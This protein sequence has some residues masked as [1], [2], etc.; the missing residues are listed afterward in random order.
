MVLVPAGEFI[1]G[2]DRVEA[3]KQAGEFGLMKPWYLDEHPQHRV[4]LPAF[5]L[6]QY[7]VT[8]AQYREFVTKAN[9]WV[10]AEWKKNG[11]L[12]TPAVLKFA[13][14]SMLRELAA[15]T[16]KLDM[17][18]ATMDKEALIQAI[19]EHQ[20]DFDRLPM[21]GVTWFNAYDYCGWAGKRLPT[22]AEWEKA[23]RGT[24][25][26][27]YPWG[28]NWDVKRM[29]AGNEGAWEY[30]VAPVGS[31]REGVSPYGVYDL[32]GN[33]MEW[34]QDWYDIY[35]NGNYKSDD[36]GVKYKVARGGGWG[37][38]GHYVLSQFYR[39]AY[40]LNLKPESAYSDIGFRCARNN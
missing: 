14:L 6:D 13:D 30:G 27:E 25:G 17:D 20:K 18:T 8:N 34:V 19:A 40:R 9:Y 22:E 7:E 38:V 26:R 2:S 35:P 33:V 28:N 32:A 1:M 11:Y 23:A 21:T 5:W 29:N 37:G 31:Y 36:Y 24:D 16:F 4:A 3:D 12:L 15:D 39:A 10:P